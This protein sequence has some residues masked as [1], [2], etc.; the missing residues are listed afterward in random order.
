MENIPGEHL[1]TD[2]IHYQVYYPNHDHRSTSNRFNRTK[3]ELIHIKDVPCWICGSKEKREVHHFHVEWAFS[4]GVD[5][6]K[7]KNLHPTYDWSQFKIPEDF[8]DH[9]YNMMVLCEDHHRGPGTGIH[10]IP[11]PIWVMQ[12][13]KKSDFILI[14][15]E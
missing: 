12:K 2:T 4:D 13:H 7:M 14:E 6:E 3:H 8:V 10:H 9:E 1:V 15:H 5:W 11:Y